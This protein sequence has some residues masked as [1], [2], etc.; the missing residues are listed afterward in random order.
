[1]PQPPTPGPAA[2]PP[3][4]GERARDTLPTYRPRDTLPT[5]RPRDRLATWRPA[6]EMSD[7]TPRA[8]APAGR[9]L[10]ASTVAAAEPVG[11][12]AR[13]DD[14]EPEEGAAADQTLDEPEAPAILADGVDSASVSSACDTPASGQHEHALAYSYGLGESKDLQ[15][16][17]R[18]A[19]EDDSPERFRARAAV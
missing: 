4:E 13:D 6:A 14:A 17:I 3:E 8:G 16:L 18:L 7:G 2:S 12:A 1:M 10:F 9:Q 11:G 19:L 15:E 5:W